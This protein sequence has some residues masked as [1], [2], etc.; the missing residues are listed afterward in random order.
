[1]LD[2]CHHWQK[3]N[4]KESNP[5]PPTSSAFK[6]MSDGAKKALEFE[7]AKDI[8]VT[9][10]EGAPGLSYAAWELWQRTVEVLVE[11]LVTLRKEP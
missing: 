3:K 1:M 4:G 8:H 10:Y 5:I 9:D 2:G 7:K 11:A 6:A